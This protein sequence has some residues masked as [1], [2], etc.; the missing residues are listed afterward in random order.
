MKTLKNTIV[1]TIIAATSITTSGF[2]GTLNK[3]V[4]AS[5]SPSTNLT[6][7]LETNF[8]SN[9][10]YQ[11]Q[12]LDSNPVVVPKLFLEYPLF[13]GGSLQ[14]S[15]EQLF[16]TKGSTL[17]RSTYNVGLA[18]TLGKFTLTPGYEFKEF[19]G[20]DRGARVNSQGVNAA[21]SFVGRVSFNDEG[22]LPVTLNPYAYISQAFE[23]RGGTFYEAGVR[24]GVDL[25]KLKV[26]FP[27]SVGVGSNNYWTP[28]NSNY[29]Y[30]FT[31]AGVSLVYDVTDRLAVRAGSTYFNTDKAVGNSSRNFVQNTAGVSVSF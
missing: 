15:T 21:Q 14:L 27:V 28:S 18:V 30:G 31:S 29:T 12:V 24:P 10:T 19:P 3:T 6:G 2:A 9:F 16:G 4:N 22:L 5:V 25:G 23:P 26:G 8:V 11:G 7:R 17:F 13:N 1:A 20:G